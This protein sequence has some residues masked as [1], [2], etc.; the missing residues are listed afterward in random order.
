[1]SHLLLGEKIVFD[2][3]THQTRFSFLSKEQYLFHL[4]IET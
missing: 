3:K 4:G 2:T 1:M